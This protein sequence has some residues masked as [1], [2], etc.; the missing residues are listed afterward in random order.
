MPEPGTGL[1]YRARKGVVI[2]SY[3]IWSCVWRFVRWRLD[4]RVK[5]A[6]ENVQ[7]YRQEQRTNR[8]NERRRKPRQGVGPAGADGVDCFGFF[9]FF[10]SRRSRQGAKIAELQSQLQRPRWR[11]RRL[12]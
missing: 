8:K 1:T 10:R 4:A 5:N 9:G 2:A 12:A 6:D 11:R 3:R 7:L